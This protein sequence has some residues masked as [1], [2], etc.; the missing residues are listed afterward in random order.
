MRGYYKV[1][2]PNNCMLLVLYIHI[3]YVVSQQVFGTFFQVGVSNRI[4][5][6]DDN[7]I[8]LSKDR[9]VTGQQVKCR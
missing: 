2:F 9:V 1:A 7:G 8:V 6:V 3:S 5:F 4:G